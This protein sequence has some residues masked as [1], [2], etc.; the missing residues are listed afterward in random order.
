MTLPLPLFAISDR[1]FLANGDLIGWISAL[2]AARVAACQLREKD[3]DD[4]DLY[5]LALR[6]KAA[7]PPPCTLWINGRVD[8]AI[9][10]QAEGVHLPSETSGGLSVRAVRRR[11]PRPFGIGV[12]THSV[13]EVGRAADEGADYAVFGPVFAT[14]SK[15]AFGP[16]LGLD[17][18]ARAT[19]VGLPLLAL[20]GVTAERFV[21][22][23][24]AGAQGAAGI[25]L[26]RTPENLPAVIE[27]ARVAFRNEDRA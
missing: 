2:A 18:L 11:F 6:A 7:L 8:V 25:R 20:G 21:D 23:A 4:R 17:A 15:A 9:A 19:Q 24:A 5:E 12:S 3:L 16:P 14:P 13:E 27:A 1:R 26:F 22:L 10:V